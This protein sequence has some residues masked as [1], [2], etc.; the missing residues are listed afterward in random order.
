MSLKA[1]FPWFGGKSRVAHLVWDAF[2]ADVANYVEPFAGSL[3]VLLGRPGEPRVETVNDLDCYLA[4][5]WRAVAADPE[6]VAHHADWPVNEVDLHARHRWLV[7]QRDFRERMRQDME[8]FDAKVAGLWVWGISQWIGSGWCAQPAWEE[9]AEAGA[10]KG[11]GIRTAEYAKRPMLDKPGRGVH[12]LAVREGTYRDGTF[13][14][15]WNVSLAN[16]VNWEGRT[17]AGRRA[18]GIHA[19]TARGDTSSTWRQRPNLGSGNGVHGQQLR[20]Q[21]PMLR[22]NSGAVGAGVHASGR[23]GSVLEWMQALATRLRHVR[24]CCGDWERVL[25][26]SATVAIG[27]TAVFLDPPYSAEAGRDPSL[28]A[29]EDLDVAHSVREWAIA[30]GD[31]PRFRIVLCGYEGEHQM[32]ESW[33]CVAWKASGGYAASAGNTANARRERVWFSPHCLGERQ[34][35]LALWG[36]R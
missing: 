9:Q 34:P 24:V 32:P 10:K 26:P 4:N 6:G 2:G 14:T 17:N 13:K 30:H 1:P 19:R 31:N 18:Q 23:R 21:M 3:A 5:F 16:S 27:N 22:G 12:Q 8:Y 7:S 25:G 35:T 33:R 28:Y 11:V 20:E 15:S 29:Q 36:T